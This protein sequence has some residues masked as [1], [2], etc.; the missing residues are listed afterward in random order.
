MRAFSV[1]QNALG[2]SISMSVN[3]SFVILLKCIHINITK[4]SLLVFD[5]PEMV[6]KWV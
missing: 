3:K 4:T 6:Y 2:H 5:G 1:H